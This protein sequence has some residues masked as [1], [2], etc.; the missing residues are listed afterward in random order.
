MRS[1]RDV[2][3]YV[4]DSSFGSIGEKRKTTHGLD[5]RSWPIAPFNEQVLTTHG[6]HRVV[7]GS[8]RAYRPERTLAMRCQRA[9]NSEPILLKAVRR[10]NVSGA[11]AS[12]VGCRRGRRVPG[13]LCSF[14]PAGTVSGAVLGVGA[15][16]M[17]A[18]H[19]VVAALLTSISFGAEQA[20][21][22][23]DW[24]TDTPDRTKSLQSRLVQMETA[25]RSGA[26]KKIGSVL[27]ARHGKLIYEAYFDGDAA[28][29][30]DTRS[31]T[32]SIT[33]ALVGLAISDGSL[34]STQ[35]RI[36]DV[37]P[38]R[39]QRMQNIDPRKSAISVED[40]LTMSS[41]LE[42]DDWNDASRGNEERMYLVEDWAQFVLDLPIRGRSHL[43][44][45]V[46]APPIRPF[47]QLR[48]RRC[49]CAERG[50]REDRPS[51]RRPI[52]PGAAV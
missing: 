50:H 43:G 47:F 42:C 25:I 52:R 9:S 39:A 3:R 27:I 31:V 16:R 8:S 17:R 45:E 44:N 21:F 30:R 15:K 10:S 29:L 13:L 33:G 48:H 36:L 14:F 22:A 51:S 23:T 32:K 1:G 34:A 26:F 49:F 19:I 7:A 20:A 4:C 5:V 28:T 12:N 37:L 41:P 38:G 40:F 2:W 11:K 46:T 35:V 18:F 24:P 6:D